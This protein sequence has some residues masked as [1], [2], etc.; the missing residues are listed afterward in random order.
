MSMWLYD[1]VDVAGAAATL[2]ARWPLAV[3]GI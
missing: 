1:P 2:L 3:V